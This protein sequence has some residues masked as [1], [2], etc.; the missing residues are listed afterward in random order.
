M[1]AGGVL[2]LGL[3]G[4][5]LALATFA[6]E[7]REF[8]TDL[9]QRTGSIFVAIAQRLGRL[10]GVGQFGG[11]RVRRR[12]GQLIGQ[13]AGPLLRGGLRA[14][15]PASADAAR[16]SSLTDVRSWASCFV[17]LSSSVR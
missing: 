8:D 9:A 2:A 10:G 17:A 1:L 5:E 16:S 14:R 13:L 3:R 4:V 11:H 12:G 15:S 6:A 7:D